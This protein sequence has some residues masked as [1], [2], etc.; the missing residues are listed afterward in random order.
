MRAAHVAEKRNAEGRVWLK[1]LK[2]DH[3]EGLV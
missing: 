1:S 3:L 2:N